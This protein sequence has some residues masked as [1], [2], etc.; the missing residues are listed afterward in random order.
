MTKYEALA[1]LHDRKRHF[2]LNEKYDRIGP[3]QS[4]INSINGSVET[5]FDCISEVG[6]DYDPSPT[7]ATLTEWKDDKWQVTKM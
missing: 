5:E 6:L 2:I 3:I 4:L 7:T 1:H